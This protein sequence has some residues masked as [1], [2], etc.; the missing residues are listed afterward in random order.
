MTFLDSKVLVYARSTQSPWH[1]LAQ[2]TMDQLADAGEGRWSSG[3]IRREYA[4]VLTRPGALAQ[5][6]T[7]ARTAIRPKPRRPGCCS[8]TTRRALQRT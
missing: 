4:A 3:Q 8:A 6:L 2:A 7:G 1:Q 5:P